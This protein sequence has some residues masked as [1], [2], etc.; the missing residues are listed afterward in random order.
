LDCALWPGRAG[1]QSR[2]ESAKVVAGMD[3]TTGR[4]AW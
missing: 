2:K 4:V 1:N 3:K